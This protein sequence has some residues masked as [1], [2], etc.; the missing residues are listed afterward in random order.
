LVP[1]TAI[2]NVSESFDTIPASRRTLPRHPSLAL[3][4]LECNGKNIG[5][6]IGVAA[7]VRVNLALVTQNSGDVNRL[8]NID[9]DTIALI[10]R[11]SL[12]GK[13][14]SADR[15]ALNRVVPGIVL[16]NLGVVAVVSSPDSV[17]IPNEKIRSLT[18]SNM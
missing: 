6:G 13:Q 8:G 3:T 16:T 2:D 12:V 11:K 5:A 18:Q 9:E 1:S 4:G 14:V 7:V 10:R 17:L 15:P